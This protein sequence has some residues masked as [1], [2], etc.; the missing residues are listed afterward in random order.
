MKATVRIKNTVYTRVLALVFIL[1]GCS[2][3]SDLTI[4]LQP[5]GT[6]DARLADTLVETI[7]QTYGVKVHLL[8]NSAFPE[9]AFIHTKTARY[10]ADSLIRFL[11]ND[12]SDSVDY[13][14]GLTNQDISFTKR[15]THGNIKKPHSTYSDW[16]I[17]GLGY[18]PGSSCI[19]SSHRLQHPDRTVF[20]ARLK[21]VAIHE[22]GH[23]FGLPHCDSTGCVMQDAVETIQTIDASSGHL[24]ASCKKL[25]P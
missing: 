7:S 15:D 13:I 8:K 16:G 1:S 17:F 25:L 14:M 24:C 18:M 21:K 23:N 10:R 19:V 2:G 5:Y 4:V 20:I 22:L 6:F 12:K 9:D 3:K 11:K